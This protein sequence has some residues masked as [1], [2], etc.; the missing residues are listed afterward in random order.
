MTRPNTASAFPSGHGAPAITSA[1][2]TR[3]SR[4][5]VIHIAGKHYA[6]GIQ[7]LLHVAARQ[8]SIFQRRRKQA[9]GRPGRPRRDRCTRRP[10]S[11]RCG[12][13]VA[14]VQA[15]VQ[16]SRWERIQTWALR[17]MAVARRCRPSVAARVQ[18]L[19]RR[20]HQDSGRGKSPF[21]VMWAGCV[22]DKGLEGDGCYKT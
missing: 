16:G 12:E 3:Q 13:Y 15:A 18:L 20:R 8:T 14:E 4:A 22:L 1:V 7:K 6:S 5:T 10:L 17:R 2:E 11:R 21:L 9:G 19:R